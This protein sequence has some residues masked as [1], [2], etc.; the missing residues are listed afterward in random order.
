MLGPSWTCVLMP[1]GT[2]AGRLK[3]IAAGRPSRMLTEDYTVRLEQFQGPLDLLLYLARKAEVDIAEI[4]I[5]QIADQYVDHLQGIDRIDI[6]LAGEFLV[7][8]ATLMELKS[9]LVSPSDPNQKSDDSGDAEGASESEDGAVD[10]RSELIQQLLAYKSFRDAADALERRRD[11][12]QRRHPAGKAATDR[13]SMLEAVQRRN[14][15]IEL[16]DLGVFDLVEAYEAVLER[17]N[18][19]RLGAHHVT[20]DADD[21]PIEKHAENLLE[22]LGEE[23]RPMALREVF[24]GRTRGQIVGLFVATLE[25]VRRRLV[26]IEFTNDVDDVTI[27]IR[28]DDGDASSDSESDAE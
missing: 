11:T 26:K 2:L 20:L 10:L 22:Q 28:Q 7:M 1:K 6:D 27:A 19:D 13:D 3:P 17:V 21:T 15:S 9:R 25:L 14:E 23:A 18:F 24:R 16:E 5:A 8:A 4:P 12:W